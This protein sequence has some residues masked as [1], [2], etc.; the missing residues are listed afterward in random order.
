MLN[1]AKNQVTIITLQNLKMEW[2]Y[3]ADGNAFCML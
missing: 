3:L 1:Y 2:E